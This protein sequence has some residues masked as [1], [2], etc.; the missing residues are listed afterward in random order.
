[1]IVKGG[2][3]GSYSQKSPELRLGRSRG[4]IHKPVMPLDSAAMARISTLT[5]HNIQKTIQ[6]LP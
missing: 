1:M 2:A 6:D 5:H 3:D 4:K